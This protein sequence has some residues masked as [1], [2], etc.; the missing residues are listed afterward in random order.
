M[1]RPY[2]FI[3]GDPIGQMAMGWT[4][5]SPVRAYNRALHNFEW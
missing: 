3:A 5:G 4:Y 2:G 1:L